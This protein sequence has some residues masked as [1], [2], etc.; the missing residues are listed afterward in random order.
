MRM[1]GRKR[2]KVTVGL[3]VFVVFIVIILVSAAI[4]ISLNLYFEEREVAHA[5]AFR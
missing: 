5:M 4:G 2:S 3:H 1:S